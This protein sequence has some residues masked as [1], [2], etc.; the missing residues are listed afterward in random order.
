MRIEFKG[1]TFEGTA[2]ECAVFAR[3]SNAVEVDVLCGCGAICEG[4]QIGDFDDDGVVTEWMTTERA[5]RE[6]AYVE[7]HATRDCHMNCHAS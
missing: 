3:S 7:R 4:A 2:S 1:G 6:L 5:A